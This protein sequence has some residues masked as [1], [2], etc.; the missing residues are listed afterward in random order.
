MATELT[1]ALE[2]SKRESANPSPPAAVVNEPPAEASGPAP[3]KPAEPKNVQPGK[4]PRK[5]VET[6]PTAN[7][8]RPPPAKPP[9]VAGPPPANR[10]PV[11]N[12][13]RPP[14]PPPVAVPLPRPNSNVS[15]VLQPVMG[16]G[17]PPLFGPRLPPP[18]PMY[19][20]YYE[21]A[22]GPWHFA[23]ESFERPVG[24]GNVNLNF[25]LPPKNLVVNGRSS[26]ECK[27]ACGVRPPGPE[28]E[29]LQY[30]PPPQNQSCWIK[31]TLF[32]DGFWNEQKVKKWVA[33]Q[34]EKQFPEDPSHKSPSPNNGHQDPSGSKS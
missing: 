19:P 6:G 10:P 16:G 23:Y 15:F 9:G 29:P 30:G 32:Y 22:A 26:A 4:L 14:P 27:N 11:A 24:H 21:Y 7:G 1:E 28:G 3:V 33:E 5:E 12:A 8:L 13:P 34:V 17:M 20:N 31:P 2:S 25:G 18:G